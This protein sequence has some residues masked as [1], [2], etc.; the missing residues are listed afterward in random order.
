[1]PRWRLYHNV[2]PPTIGIET[3]NPKLDLRRRAVPTLHPEPSPG[4][5]PTLDRPR[6]AGV[7]AFGFGGTNFHAVLEAY[8]RN[9]VA[10]PESTVSDWPAELLVWQ[11]DGPPICWSS[12]RSACPVRSI[13][14][15]AALSLRPVARADRGAGD[16]RWRRCPKPD[17][18]PWRS[19]PHRTMTC[20]KSCSSP[21]RRSPRAETSLDD[22]R[23][24]VFEAKPAWA[25]EPVAFHLPGPGRPVARHAP[26]AGRHFP[27]SARSF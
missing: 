4:S 8:D 24:I 3:P 9:V 5:I 25:G 15:L 12:S 16:T 27:R 11:A 14:E 1:M 17:T 26:G 2:L 20:A 13:R 23:G 22:P 18:R 21:G 6:R 19:S 7:S 10:R